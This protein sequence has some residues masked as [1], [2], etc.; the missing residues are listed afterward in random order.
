LDRTYTFKVNGVT[1]TA[2]SYITYDT[3]LDQIVIDTKGKVIIGS[4]QL[5]A[6]MTVTLDAY[7]S[8]TRTT[9]FKLYAIASLYP[10]KDFPKEVTQY[11]GGEPV[12]VTFG[13]FAGTGIAPEE[14]TY[15]VLTNDSST[16]PEPILY[17]NTNHTWTLN[18]NFE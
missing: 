4:G 9:K 15:K 2:T 18:G 6:E 7:S 12:Y 8:V 5:D 13:D 17:D 1:Q 14:I 16:L 10:P 3:K 11:V